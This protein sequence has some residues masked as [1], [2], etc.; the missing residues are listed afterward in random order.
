LRAFLYLFTVCLFFASCREEKEFLQMDSIEDFYPLQVGKSITYRLDSTIFARSGTVIEVHK[1][2]VKH[3]VIQETE[4][5]GQKAYLVQRLINNE[6]ATGPWVNNGTYLVIPSSR[7]VETLDN[8][9]RVVNLQ[10][11]LRQDFSWK[12]NSQLPF[13]PYQQL[14][15]MSTG[16]DM[17]TWDF[18][19]ASFGNE[20][21]QGQHYENVW[22]VEQRDESLNI[23]PTPQTSIGFKERSVEKYAKGIGLVYKDFQLY[24]YQGAGG[25]DNP[26]AH[27]IGFG[28]TMWMIHHN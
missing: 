17:N 25:S 22:T 10:A 3:T 18:Y 13:A 14:F 23:P 5:N 21:I 16:Y 1:Y 8:N 27:Y 7:K 2:Q 20:D 26:E 9:L 4:D 11:P 19:Y 24:E 15:E 28:I 12:G 6:N